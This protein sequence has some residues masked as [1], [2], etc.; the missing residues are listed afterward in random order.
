M[1]CRNTK[2]TS[3]QNMKLLDGNTISLDCHPYTP[4]VLSHTKGVYIHIFLGFYVI[5]IEHP[6]GVVAASLHNSSMLP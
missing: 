1:I 6:T 3:L 4:E 5:I 2:K